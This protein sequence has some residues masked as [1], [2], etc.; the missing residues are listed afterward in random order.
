ML[1][2]QA[3]NPAMRAIT[4]LN[5]GAALY[6]A[7]K[8]EELAEGVALADAALGSGDAWRKLE[9]LIRYSHHE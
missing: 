8:A 5:A 4:V 7:G 3:P 9:Q 2:D 1:K 6:I